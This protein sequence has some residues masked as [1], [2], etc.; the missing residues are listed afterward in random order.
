MKTIKFGYFNFCGI[1]NDHAVGM[2]PY[3]KLSECQSFK[4]YTYQNICMTATGHTIVLKHTVKS[5]IYRENQTG[6]FF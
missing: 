4:V 6:H 5:N 3:Y 1:K 2:N